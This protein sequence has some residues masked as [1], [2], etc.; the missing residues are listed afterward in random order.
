MNQ[1]EE[2]REKMLRRVS[3]EFRVMLAQ[4]ED[5]FGYYGDFDH[6][7]KLAEFKPKWQTIPNKGIIN[8]IRRHF[9]RVFTEV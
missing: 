2:E 7:K 8:R 4:D 6:F 3:D 1:P 9:Y 5:N